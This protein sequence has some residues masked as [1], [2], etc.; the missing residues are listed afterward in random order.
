MG[1]LHV[2]RILDSTGSTIIEHYACPS[3]WEQSDRALF[4]LDKGRKQ[5][6]QLDVAVP[7][8]Y[9]HRC[10]EERGESA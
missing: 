10:K 6:L 5:H 3:H 2:H 8:E 9:C 7:S 1:T 4:N